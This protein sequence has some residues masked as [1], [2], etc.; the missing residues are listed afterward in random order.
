MKGVYVLIIQV[1]KPVKVQIKSLGDTEFVPSVWAYVG[2]AMGT[3]STSLKNR[4]RR[5]F[6]KEKTIYW[7]ID[8]LLNEDIEIEKAIWAQSERHLECDLA[9]SLASNNEFNAGPKGFGAS[10][11]K[12]GCIAHIFKHQ[13]GKAIDDVLTG[14]FVGLDLQPQSTM[15]G[16]L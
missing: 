6:R 4:L 14:I 16:I 10:D 9:Q 3:G 13:N 2:S 11:C 15:D 5:H 7:H 12:S 1:K 8:Y